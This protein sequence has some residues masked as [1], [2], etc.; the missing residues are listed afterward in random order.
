MG[1]AL[2]KC[3]E[4]LTAR[5]EVL[6]DIRETLAKIRLAYWKLSEITDPMLT[7]SVIFELRSLEIRH[8]YLLQKYKGV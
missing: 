2:K 4:E 6:E 8:K 5:D 1:I 3:K 7:E